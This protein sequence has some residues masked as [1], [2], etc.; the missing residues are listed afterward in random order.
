[1][2]YNFVSNI[3]IGFNWNF[4]KKAFFRWNL[5]NWAY[6]KE[7]KSIYYVELK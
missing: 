2:L 5:P 6:D 4:Q 1:M 7:T 3:P